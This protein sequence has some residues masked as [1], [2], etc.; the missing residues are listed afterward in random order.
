M[1]ID[2]TLQAVAAIIGAVVVLCGIAVTIV[3][4]LKAKLN[5]GTDMADK[6]LASDA[7]SNLQVTVEAVK[8]QNS[9]QAGQITQLTTNNKTLS[10]EVSELR[11]KVD[12]LSTI[13]L[14]KIEKHMADTNKILQAILPLIPTSSI[15]HTVLETTT[16]N[17]QVQ[18]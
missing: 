13:P 14:D 16:T 6:E 5:K 10:S 15:Q 9:L 1:Y 2:N 3:L 12:T 18:S 4:Y 17:S 7:I 11:G 8:T